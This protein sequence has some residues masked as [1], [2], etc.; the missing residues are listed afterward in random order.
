MLQVAK[1]YFGVGE[2]ENSI[3]GHITYMMKE[4]RKAF[5]DQEKVKNAM[6]RIFDA[7]R[8]SCGVFL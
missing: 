3:N 1:A 6:D 2:D 7:R 5:S 8:H 4:S